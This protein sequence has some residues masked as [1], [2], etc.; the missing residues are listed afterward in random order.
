MLDGVGSSV[1][2]CLLIGR[3]A[4]PREIVTSWDWDRFHPRA[5]LVGRADREA[6]DLELEIA[7]AKRGYLLSEKT[8]SVETYLCF[9]EPGSASVRRPLDL[10]AEYHRFGNEVRDAE[11]TEALRDNLDLEFVRT[12]Y[13]L[14][15]EKAPKEIVE[16]PKCE[17]VAVEKRLTIQGIFEVADRLAESHCRVL[18]NSDI[19]LD[20][21]CFRLPYLIGNGEFYALRR[22][23]A[24]GALNPRGGLDAWCWSGACQVRGADFEMGRVQCDLRLNQLAREA[25][26][27]GFFC[28]SLTFT[29]HHRHESGLRLGTSNLV[30]RDA[31]AVVGQCFNVRTVQHPFEVAVRASSGDREPQKTV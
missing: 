25:Y 24:D 8:G 15:G 3:E 5:I 28:P 18:T 1:I 26:G 27:G 9:P 31:F 16:H 19:V 22:R 21:N 30:E 14:D 20:E 29:I 23:E 11:I 7:L 4:G 2:D 13:L 12:L 17:I 6:P 10:F